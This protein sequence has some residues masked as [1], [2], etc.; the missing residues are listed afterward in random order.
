MVEIGLASQEASKIG[1]K[2]VVLCIFM[3]VC[4]IVMWKWIPEMQQSRDA[5]QC[6][7]LPS[8]NLEA[9]EGDFVEGSKVDL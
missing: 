9:L 1:L 2:L 3:L 8:K 7:R 4:A 5:A 6:L